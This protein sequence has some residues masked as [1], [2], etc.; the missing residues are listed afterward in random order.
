MTQTK[1]LDNLKSWLQNKCNNLKLN[2]VVFLAI[3]STL[4]TGP[5]VRILSNKIPL[6]DDADA[7]PKRKLYP[8]DSVE[9]AELKR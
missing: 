6:R 9:L 1:L 2:I 4:L 7:P 5:H 3:R 8:L